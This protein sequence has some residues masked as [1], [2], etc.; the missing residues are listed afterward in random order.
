[1]KLSGVFRRMFGVVLLC[2]LAVAGC[3]ES[4]TSPS[5]FAPFSKTD[6]RAGTGA[7]VVVGNA[8]T[9]NYTGW[10]YD[11]TKSEQK[12]P[13]FDSSIGSTPFAFTLGAGQVIEGWD[14]GIV[15]MKVGGVRRLVI[16]PSLAYGQI[17]SGPIPPNATLVFEIELLTAAQ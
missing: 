7:E 13:Q 8:L 6:I 11:E 9:V 16:P 15:G 12:G 1:V 2:A 5:H 14:Q 10:L 4:P 17:R 3:D